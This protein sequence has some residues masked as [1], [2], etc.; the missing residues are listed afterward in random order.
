MGRR[1]S[2][3][4][5][6]FFV[7]CLFVG[8]GSVVW[9]ASALA[10][11][12]PA[13]VDEQFTQ[14]REMVLYARYPDAERIVA[15][16]LARR[17]V[18]PAQRNAAME[19]QAIILLARRQTQRADAVLRELYGRDPDHRLAERDVGPNVVA[20]FE[21]MRDS[22]PPTAT[23]TMANITPPE[24]ETREAPEIAVRIEAGS[25]VVEEMRLSYRNGTSGPFEQVIMRFDEERTLA[26]TRLPPMQGLDGYTVQFYVD[27]LAPSDAVV[28][29]LGSE[30]E[31]MSLEVPRAEATQVLADGSVVAAPAGEDFTWVWAIVGVILAGGI[32]ATLGVV[33][34]TDLVILQDGSLGTGRLMR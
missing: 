27:A 28:R 24:M 29:S 26:R 30:A 21:R 33:L 20:A 1:S 34:G 13:N 16:I 7:A 32:A 5:S 23:V 14:L 12:E 2:G 18:T 8:A 22:H 19:I 17:D 25:D 4:A 10:Q 6:L 31:P 9:T 15:D 11:S 3:R